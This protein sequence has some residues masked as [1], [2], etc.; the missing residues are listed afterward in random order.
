LKNNVFCYAGIIVSKILYIFAFVKCTKNM[1]LWIFWLIAFLLLA[2]VEVMTQWL[3]TFCFAV[4]SLV[5]LLLSLFGV[6]PLYQLLALGIVALIAFVLFAPY[7]QRL[8]ER[9]GKA[10]KGQSNMDALIGRRATVV[11]DIVTDGIGRVKIDGD[12]WQAKSTDRAAIVR[13][14]QVEIVNYDSIVL[15]VKQV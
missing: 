2:V 10:S 12:N 7:F 5:A 11:E 1:E 3:T 4:G 15:I 8:H 14:A 13:N 6:S 9:K